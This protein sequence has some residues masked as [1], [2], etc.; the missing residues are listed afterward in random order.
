[1]ALDS[2]VGAEELSCEEHNSAP[3]SVLLKE[4]AVDNR[5]VNRGNNDDGGEVTGEA[6]VG[7]NSVRFD[8]NAKRFAAAVKWYGR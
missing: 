2:P 5:N 3:S 6:T 1:M 8:G 7:E 4:A